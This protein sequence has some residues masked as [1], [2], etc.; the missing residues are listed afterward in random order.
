MV[1]AA[2]STLASSYHTHFTFPLIFPFVMASS[3]E[4][5]PAKRRVGRRRLPPLAQGPALQFVV[6]NHPD[7][8]RAGKVMRNVRS[9]VMYKHREN[10]GSSP[11]DL[12][13]SQEGNSAPS[14]MTPSPSPT[15]TGSG[16]RLQIPARQTNTSWE[17]DPYDIQTP[18]PSTNPVRRL[19]AQILTGARSV[20]TRSASPTFEGASEYPFPARD[21]M[22]P[23]PLEDLRHN[24]IATT[25]FF[26]HSK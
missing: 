24:W 17:Q 10:N 21:T 19:A 3:S 7:D 12:G 13:S 25:A 18:S 6:A 1:V 23:E 9:H 4:S 2:S 16:G 14:N 26:C 8:F 22:S 15:T 5:K 20:P 11:T